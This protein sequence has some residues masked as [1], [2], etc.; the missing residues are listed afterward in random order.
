MKNV[1]KLIK[2]DESMV[3]KLTGLSSEVFSQ[4]ASIWLP[5]GAEDANIQPPGYDSEDMMAYMI[6]HLDVF[7]IYQ[8]NNLIGGVVITAPIS[9][10]ARIDRIF[11]DHN[12]QGKGYGKKAIQLIE[13]AYPNVKRWQLETSARQTNNRYF[14]ESVGYECVWETEEL[15][16]EKNLS[17]CK[18][19]NDHIMQKQD[20]DYTRAELISINAQEVKLTDA[21]I[22]SLHISN[23][24]MQQTKLQNVNLSDSIV[25]DATVQN[26]TF[27]FADLSGSVFRTSDMSGVALENCNIS[28][29]TI[30]GI[31]VEELMKVY[32]KGN[33][34]GA[35]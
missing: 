6:T 26:A 35:S 3:K 25:A 20:Q 1:I 8:G 11:I 12:L 27:W 23:A 13:K 28:G 16:F 18:N 9:T 32:E 21:N 30:D 33:R 10:Y 19:R 4:E 5:E 17:D 31:S 2:A 24:A 7:G 15:M 29:M 14:Y 34:N 22:R